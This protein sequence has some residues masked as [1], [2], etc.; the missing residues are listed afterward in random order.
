MR[1]ANTGIWKEGGPGK[2][3]GPPLEGLAFGDFK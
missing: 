3:P 1:F 2:R